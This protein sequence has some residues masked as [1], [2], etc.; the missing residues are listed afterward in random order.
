MSSIADPASDDWSLFLSA[1]L[2]HIV[3]KYLASF[4]T[5]FTRFSTGT[6]QVP[7]YHGST[8]RDDYDASILV[9]SSFVNYSL[10][11]EEI[12]MG[13]GKEKSF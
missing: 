13:F 9:S 6:V 3:S 7:E 12:W 2:S 11:L 5:A 8:V 4:A 10:T 1:I